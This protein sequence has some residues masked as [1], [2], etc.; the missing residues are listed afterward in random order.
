M[1]D[2]AAVAGKT[3]SVETEDDV[4]ATSLPESA[5]A[6][7]MLVAAGELSAEVETA[8]VAMAD[9]DLTGVGDMEA[10]A[11]GATV[12]DSNCWWVVDACATVGPID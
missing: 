9:T 3:P 1:Y 4:M 7:A 8:V 10:G 11:V 12:D 2:D 6:D 5:E